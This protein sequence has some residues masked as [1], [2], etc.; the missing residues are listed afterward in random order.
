MLHGI[1]MQIED[2]VAMDID[3]ITNAACIIWAN[4]SRY[5][6]VRVY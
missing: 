6:I 4:L 5:L 3:H 2:F 1:H